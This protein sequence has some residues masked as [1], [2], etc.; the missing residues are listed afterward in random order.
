MPGKARGQQA[1]PQETEDEAASRGGV[2]KM[3]KGCWAPGRDSPKGRG[4]LTRA[5]V[6]GPLAHTLRLSVLSKHFWPGAAFLTLD[7]IQDDTSNTGLGV[8]K[9]LKA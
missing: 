6:Q 7:K 5:W 1:S 2:Q 9:R 3:R 4:L 8:L